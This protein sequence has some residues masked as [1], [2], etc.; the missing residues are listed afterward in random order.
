LGLIENNVLKGIALDHTK[1]FYWNGK[2][3]IFRNFEDRNRDGKVLIID[4]VKNEIYIW[5]DSEVIFEA[6]PANREKDFAKDY[7]IG[8]TLYC[9]I[10]N[11]V[12]SKGYLTKIVSIEKM[13]QK[14]IFVGK[15]YNH[16]NETYGDYFFIVALLIRT[17]IFFFRKSWLSK[18]QSE[19]LVLNWGDDEKKVLNILITSESGLTTDEINDILNLSYK[20]LDNQRKLR[21]EF[22]KALNLKLYQMYEVKDVIELITLELDKRMV[23]YVLNSAIREKIKVV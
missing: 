11:S 7:V 16:T 3:F 14:A 20:T 22:L 6:I 4:P 8:D 10:Y 15:L 5:K 13:K 23:K 19:S 9:K 21:N 2:Y 12:P 1:N 17:L 18:R